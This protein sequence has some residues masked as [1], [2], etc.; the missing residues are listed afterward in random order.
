MIFKSELFK[1]NFGGFV[2]FSIKREKHRLLIIKI[3]NNS[4]KMSL[5]KNAFNI[6]RVNLQNQITLFFNNSQISIFFI[7]YSY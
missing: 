2:N 4:A 1:V 5:L 3:F 7:V 6:S